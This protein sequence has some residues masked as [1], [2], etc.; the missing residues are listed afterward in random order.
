[1][2]APRIATWNGKAGAAGQQHIAI[3]TRQL[4]QLLQ[5][6]AAP[7]LTSPHGKLS[8]DRKAA[9]AAPFP[10]LAART[11]REKREELVSKK[12]KNKKETTSICKGESSVDSK[13]MDDFSTPNSQRTSMCG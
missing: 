6:T 1:M 12:K 9:L 5:G 8:L 4:L 7:I 10:K 2:A 11:K 3:S 13:G